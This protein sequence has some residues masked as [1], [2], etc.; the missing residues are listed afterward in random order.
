MNRILD[1]GDGDTAYV[2][3]SDNEPI[4]E[5]GFYLK[6]GMIFARELPSALQGEEE[7][8]PVQPFDRILVKIK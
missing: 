8:K 5:I 1:I 7:K 3:R 2:F 6:D 4:G